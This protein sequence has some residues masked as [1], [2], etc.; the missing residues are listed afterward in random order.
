MIP[1]CMNM[2]VA[3]EVPSLRV[4][5]TTTGVSETGS[6][7]NIRVQRATYTATVTGGSGSYT[8][9]WQW[10]ESPGGS[11]WGQPIQSS[12]NPNQMLCTQSYNPNEIDQGYYNG[13][14][15]VFVTDT[16]TGITGTGDGPIISFN[17]SGGIN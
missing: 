14:G 9:L 12:P 10:S 2:M 15:W 5:V 6:G 16:V 7:L 4:V 17:T 1:A 3:S 13:Y 8:Y 11:T